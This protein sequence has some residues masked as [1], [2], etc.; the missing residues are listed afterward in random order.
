MLR[1]IRKSTPHTKKYLDSLTKIYG[2]FHWA[3][4]GIL[5]LP[6]TGKY[7]KETGLPLVYI[8]Y[9]GN[10][11]CDEFHLSTIDKASSGSFW[12]WYSTKENAAFMQ[13][14]LNNKYM[15]IGE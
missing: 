2:L 4:W 13:E 5:E 14:V 8:Y 7:N 6:W 11:T 9:D 12:N 3:K 10:G 1:K 15:P